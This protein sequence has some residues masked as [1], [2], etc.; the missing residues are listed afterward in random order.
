MSTQERNSRFQASLASLRLLTVSSH[1]LTWM[2]KIPLLHEPC[3][4]PETP[5]RSAGEGKISL[6][7]WKENPVPLSGLSNHMYRP[8]RERENKMWKQREGKKNTS[9]CPEIPRDSY[10]SKLEEEGEGRGDD[11][12]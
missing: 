2:L 3:S 1:I 8:D 4:L 12:G 5:W 10:R 11:G 9:C 6:T 7:W